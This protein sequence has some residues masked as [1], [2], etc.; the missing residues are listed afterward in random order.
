[1]IGVSEPDFGSMAKARDRA[2]PLAAE[3]ADLVGRVEELLARVKPGTEGLGVFGGD[4]LG[5][6]GSPERPGSNSSR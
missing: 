3:G 5:R 2:G 1:M 4:P 6:Q